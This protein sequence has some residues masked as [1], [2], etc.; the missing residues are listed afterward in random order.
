MEDLNRQIEYLLSRTGSIANQLG[1]WINSI[2]NSG[3]KGHRSQNVQTR[4]MAQAAK[5]RDEFPAKLRA[6]QEASAL[7]HSSTEGEPS[8]E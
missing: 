7:A 1:G 6:I 4:A 3:F 5:R 2:K 8:Q